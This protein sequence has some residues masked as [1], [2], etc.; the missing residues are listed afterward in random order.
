MTVAELIAYLQTQP[1]DMGVAFD[2][3]SEHCLPEAKSI[4]QLE[5]CEPLGW[6]GRKWREVKSAVP[7][8][9]CGATPSAGGAGQ[10]F[11]RRN[12]GIHRAAEGCPVE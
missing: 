12:A 6:D 9:H 1:Q 10:S 11:M 8:K 2:C 7:C 3:Y 4:R 5:A